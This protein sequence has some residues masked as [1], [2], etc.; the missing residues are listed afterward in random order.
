MTPFDELTLGEV[1]WM[2]KELLGGQSFSDSD[3]MQLAGAVMFMTYKRDDPN[4]NWEGFKSTTRMYD[5]KKFSELM[6]EDNEDPSSG[7]S[8]SQT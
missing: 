4:I 2:T 7:D 8:N 6:D 3:P 5:I 1:E